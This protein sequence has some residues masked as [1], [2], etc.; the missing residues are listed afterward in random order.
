M[1]R[2]WKALRLIVLPAMLV[3]AGCSPKTF[4]TPLEEAEG[5]S[6]TSYDSMMS[7]LEE[8]QRG[9]RAFTLDTIG[10]SVE[11]RSLVLLRFTGPDGDAGADGGRLKL[12][13]YAQQH[14]N[15][16]SGKEAAIA[17]AR[18]IAAGEFAEFLQNV[19]LYLIPQVNPDG[20]ELR[21]R[22]NAEEADLNR[23]HLTLSTP[24]VSA[25]HSVFNGLKP[26]ITLD[27]H[28]YSFTSSAWVE[29]GMYKDFGQ[30]IGALSNANMSMKLRSYAWDR[31]IPTMR[32]KLAPKGVQLQ[33]YLVA[34]GPTDRFR[35]STAALNDGRNSMGIYNSLSFLS[36]GRNGLTV[37]ADIRER[38]RQQL[39]TMK[40]FATF[41]SENAAEVKG[42]VEAERA[43]LAGDGLVPEV[44]LVMDYEQDPD[45]PTVTVGV[46]DVQTGARE[47]RTFE[48]FFPTLKSTLSVRRPLGYAIPAN[49]TDV[50]EVI[51][52]H[53]IQATPS[54]GPIRATVESYR[55]VAAEESWKE[56]KEFIEVDVAITRGEVVLPAGAVMVWCDQIQS[57]L[58][59]SLLE[60]QSQWGL[61]PLPEFQSLLEPG[62][63]Y[64]ILRIMEVGD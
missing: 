36:E 58:I 21:Q 30:Q 61:A 27:I 3:M 17:F 62:S 9:T 20:S 18:D 35:Y 57:N 23:A 39:E 4:S 26:E 49:L 16:P 45:R 13:M 47:T 7:F 55:M 10:S 33:R 40:A 37:E 5:D 15:E 50:L 63:L 6:L 22:R 8:L 31:V 54:D 38:T 24:E 44:A 48:N 53:G 32:E 42:L 29:A 1:S 46:V 34:D 60:P 14:G 52:R 28:E 19:E 2:G 41:F 25:L 12:L 11:G 64:P 56:D 43:K 51:G 59:V